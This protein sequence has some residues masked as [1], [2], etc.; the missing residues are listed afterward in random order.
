MPLL[1]RKGAPGIYIL[2]VRP[3]K[4]GVIIKQ[5]PKHVALKNW[6]GIELATVRPSAPD[7]DQL[8]VIYSV[9]FDCF[10][11]FFIFVFSVGIVSDGGN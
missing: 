10:C 9:L 4:T 2:S 3:K 11:I 1:S 7:S 5:K 6:S 8:F